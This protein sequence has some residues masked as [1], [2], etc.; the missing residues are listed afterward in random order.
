MHF[1]DLFLR[2]IYGIAPRWRPKFRP[3]APVGPF[4]LWQA[5]IVVSMPGFRRKPRICPFRLD[6]C[7][8]PGATVVQ[9]K[10]QSTLRVISVTLHHVQVIVH[11]KATCGAACIFFMNLNKGGDPT[12]GVF[13]CEVIVKV[14]PP[15]DAWIALMREDE[16][17]G[18]HFVMNDRVISC[19]I[20][21]LDDG[22]GFSGLII[23]KS[24]RPWF[25]VA[26]AESVMVA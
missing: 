11:V 17:V 23:Q 8:V 9:H 3:A 4:I 13:L 19:K 21:V 6:P 1:E 18:E 25:E 14:I 7:A 16:G 12:T 26:Q 5:S 15:K 10:Y 22:D 2:D 20:M 24:I